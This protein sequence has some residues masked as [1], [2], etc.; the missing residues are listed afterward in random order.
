MTN[1]DAFFQPQSVAIVGASSHE[2]TV[3]NDLVKNLV[4]QGFAGKI[5]PINPKIDTLYGL[6]VFPS[7]QQA[8]EEIDLVIIAVKADTVLSVLEQLREKRVKA[9]TV[10]SAGFKEV[11]RQDL[12]QQ[13]LEKSRELGI[14]LLGPNCLGTLQ[15][16]QRLNASFG[17]V[18]PAAGNVAFVSQSGALGAAVLDYAHNFGFGF[19]KFVSLGNK[20]Q[21]DELAFVEYLLDD[22]A[23]AVICIYAETLHPAADWFK[24]FKK[25]AAKPIIVL[26]SGRTQAGNQ[27]ALSHTGAL[28]TDDRAYE[29]LFLQTN[30][31]RAENIQ[32]MFDL[33]AVFAHN[34]APLRIGKSVAVVTNAG[35]PAVLAVD[36]LTMNGLTLASLSATTT[37]AL[38]ALTAPAAS[39]KNPID[40]LG[41]ASA[42]QFAQTLA[43]L[44]HDPGIQALL[45]LLTPQSMTDP[46]K[47]A[48]AIVAWRQ[49]SSLPIVVSF[50]GS[51]LVEAGVKILQL[52][53][54]ACLAYPE[55]AARSLAQFLA[56][57]QRS[58]VSET[59]LPTVEAGDKSLVAE[60]FA[61]AVARNQHTF[62]EQMACQ[63]LQAYHLPVLA[64]YI[65][66][67]PQ[68]AQ[69]WAMKQQR[70]VALKIVSPDI[71]HKSDVGGVS[72]HIEP[73]QVAD[74]AQTLL[75][76]VK[77]QK[78]TAT[79]EGIAVSE[80]IE[81]GLECIAGGAK[82]SL[83]TLLLFGLGGIYVEV[84]KDIGMRFLPVTREAVSSLLDNLRM[85]PLLEGVRGQ[86]P[87][88]KEAIYLLLSQMQNLLTDFPLIKEI[89]LN[90]VMVQSQR[91]VILD[92]R[93]V[94]E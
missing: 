38:K 7:L 37:T 70:P 27:A 1:L 3:G 47:T 58:S 28:S 93:I 43:I 15:P 87:V 59:P 16:S 61:Q 68:Q 29:A 62:S 60:I 32:E 55:F 73:E 22:P 67:D 56:Y 91:L 66:A 30:M 10:I 20:A 80:M 23:T 65:A 18:L 57:Y 39:L 45:V 51:N 94:I 52:N 40:L 79:L 48:H 33:A 26:K 74:A 71:L 24:L 9:V 49:Q 72:L 8:P 41:D 85:K 34:P 90:P 35:G 17:A 21:L 53:G 14:A 50:L 83:G 77:S 76:R 13:L 36:A 46:L 86:Q 42:D 69:A 75:N 44:N 92:A 11:G 81:E 54:V 88:N 78:P 84:F 2:Q 19:S 5:Y 82:N 31:I 12:E 64:S 89:D 6:S 25:K 63:I 4:Q